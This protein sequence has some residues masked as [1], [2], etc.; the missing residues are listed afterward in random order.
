MPSIW[1]PPSSSDT[2]G[3]GTSGPSGGYTKEEADLRFVHKTDVNENVLG[4]KNFIEI[5]KISGDLVFNNGTQTPVGGLLTVDASGNVVNTGITV[6]DLSGSS[7]GVSG[8][9][10]FLELTDTPNSYSG[11]EGSVVVVSGGQLGF[12]N[13]LFGRTPLNTILRKYLIVDSRIKST[14]T[15]SVSIILPAEDEEVINANIYNITNGSF[16]VELA[17]V[18]PVSGYELSWIVM[19]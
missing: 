12:Q 10:T 11:S 3:G 8:A 14:S 2:G 4:D 7:S 16:R 13:F 17:G 18:P 5:V 19:G 15:P 9:S 1:F 6:A